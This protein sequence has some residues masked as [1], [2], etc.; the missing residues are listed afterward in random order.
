EK[1]LTRR[2]KM[3]RSESS[4]QP[5]GAL[6]RCS[7]RARGW[8]C[9]AAIEVSHGG[10]SITEHSAADEIAGELK[11]RGNRLRL[12]LHRGIVQ[13]QVH[14]RFNARQIALYFFQGLLSPVNV[15]QAS[16]QNVER[17]GF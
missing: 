17:R 9:V 16:L 5:S 4:A 15:A 6:H 7:A 8:L 13:D 2:L 14:L 11:V 3:L 10:F 12:S 1:P